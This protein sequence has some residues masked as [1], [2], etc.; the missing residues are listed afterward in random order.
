LIHQQCLVTASIV[1]LATNVRR[2]A[3][4]VKSALLGPDE[5]EIGD[6]TGGAAI[7]VIE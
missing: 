2:N 5:P 6:C 3:L 7:A 4:E 1:V